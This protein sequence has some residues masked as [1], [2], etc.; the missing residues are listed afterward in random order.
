MLKQLLSF[1][2]RKS[3]KSKAKNNNSIIFEMEENSAIKIHINI[4]NKSI[5][6]AEQLGLA[7]F[8]IN[9]GYYIKDLLDIINDMYKNHPND[10]DFMQTAI[11]SWSNCISNNDDANESPIIKPTEFNISKHEN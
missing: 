2:N 9:E 1:F 10:K 4:Y 7:L 11:T 8:L 6:D 3:N 5:K